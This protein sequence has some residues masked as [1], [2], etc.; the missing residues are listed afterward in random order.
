MKKNQLYNWRNVAKYKIYGC[1][2]RLLMDPVWDV[3]NPLNTEHPFREDT[4]PQEIRQ[5]STVS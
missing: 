4:K 5:P 2:G 1:Y 3:W